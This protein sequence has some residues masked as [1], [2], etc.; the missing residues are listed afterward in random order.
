MEEK[1]SINEMIDWVRSRKDTLKNLGVDDETV[2]RYR[3]LMAE[4]GH[5]CTPKEVKAY[6]LLIKS[7]LEN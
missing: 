3:R 6:I 1:N 7:I 4:H 5:E 2:L